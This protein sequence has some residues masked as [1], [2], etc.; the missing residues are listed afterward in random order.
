MISHA[1]WKIHEAEK[2]NLMYSEA[3]QGLNEVY[4][5]SN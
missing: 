4:A 2:N 3:K 1:L 5:Q